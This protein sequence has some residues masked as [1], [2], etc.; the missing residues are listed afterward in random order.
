MVLMNK[1]TTVQQAPMC[2]IHCIFTAVLSYEFALLN[3]RNL[4]QATML[5][6]YY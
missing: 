2:T 4:A 3:N 6:Y 5:D 1:V